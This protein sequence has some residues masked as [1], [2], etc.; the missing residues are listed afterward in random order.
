MFK[1]P[2]PPL[3]EQ[4]T[5]AGIG[6]FLVINMS[7]DKSITLRQLASI[8]GASGVGRELKKCE[9]SL[10]SE[11]IFTHHIDHCSPTRYI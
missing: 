3:L 7:S 2:S 4:H 1:R 8:L 5:Q 11:A 10:Y 9:S 6:L